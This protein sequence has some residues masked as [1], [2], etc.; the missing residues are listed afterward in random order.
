MSASATNSSSQISLVTEKVAQWF[1]LEAR[2]SNWRTEI[3]AGLTTFATM[4]YVLAVNPTI[5]A[6]TG[7]DKSELITATAL[8]A[9]LFF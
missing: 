2:G 5:L 1:E 7:M 4:C 3:L 9:G 8:S 6:Q